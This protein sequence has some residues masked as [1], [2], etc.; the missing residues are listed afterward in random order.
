M[1][2]DFIKELFGKEPRL[3]FF[4]ALN[5]QRMSPIQRQY[6]PTQFDAFQNRYFGELGNQIQGGTPLGQLP[7]FQDFL[8]GYTKADGTTYVKGINFQNEFQSLPPSLRPG[9]NRQS[10]FAPPVRFLF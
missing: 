8:S 7:S 10:Q 2:P 5:N 9:G 4:G 6:F 3:A 1:D